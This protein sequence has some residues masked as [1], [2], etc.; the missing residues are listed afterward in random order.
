MTATENKK[1]YSSKS[2]ITL[3]TLTIFKRHAAEIEGNTSP[4]KTNVC[5]GKPV[6]PLIHKLTGKKKPGIFIPG[7]T[8]I[9]FNY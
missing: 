7:S 2:A 3:L 9:T 5:K 6:E 8:N 1:T 4:I